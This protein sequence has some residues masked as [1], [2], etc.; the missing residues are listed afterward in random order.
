MRHR[1]WHQVLAVVRGVDNRGSPPVDP[2]EQ[3]VEKAA[4]GVF[5]RGSI[6]QQ[7]GAVGRDQPGGKVVGILEVHSAQHRVSE[8]A[9]LAA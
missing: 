8:R 6:L 2:F 1:D 9:L 5:E 7:R 3:A 4:F